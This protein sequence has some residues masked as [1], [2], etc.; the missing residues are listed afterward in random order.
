MCPLKKLW[1]IEKGRLEVGTFGREDSGIDPGM[2]RVVGEDMRKTDAWYL[3][4]GNQ[5]CGRT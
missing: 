4:R 5:P 2:R 3:S 1:P